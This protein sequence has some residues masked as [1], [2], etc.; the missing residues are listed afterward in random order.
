MTRI[1][2]NKADLEFKCDDVYYTEGLQ[3]A[4]KL[5][6]AVLF[7]KNKDCVG[8]AHNQIKGSNNVFIAKI[9]GVWRTFINSKITF[10]EGK[11]FTHE[12]SCMS[13]PNKSSKVIRWN[14][15]ELTHQVKARNDNYG[16]MFEKE[17][18]F[19]FN[20]CIIQHEVDHLNG[21][22]IFNKNKDTNNAL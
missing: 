22:H 4:K 7:G 2:T 9:D 13:F 14:K 20:A 19:G 5:K 1:T 21:I 17:L 15:I 18:F 10:F 16:D 3:I 6:Q 11:K 8:L 12:E